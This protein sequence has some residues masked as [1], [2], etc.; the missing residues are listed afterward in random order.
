MT[1]TEGKLRT[2]FTPTAFKMGLKPV[3]SEEE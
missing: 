3:Y 2:T 1:V